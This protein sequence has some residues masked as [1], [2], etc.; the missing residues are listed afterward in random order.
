VSGT[1]L[2]EGETN[3]SGVLVT[4]AGRPIPRQYSANGAWVFF[5]AGTTLE[6]TADGSRVVFLQ[7]ETL[8]VSNAVTG[9]SEGVL[10]ER[11]KSFK[12]SQ[13]GASVLLVDVTGQARVVKIATKEAHLLAD[14]VVHASRMDNTRVVLVR[15]GSPPPSNFQDGGY[16]A[17][18]P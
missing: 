5:Q 8:R 3:H 14:R 10:W 7:G 15:D 6:F 17:T 2:L 13:D 12:I 11:A 9:A 16:V 4:L 18:V 1:V